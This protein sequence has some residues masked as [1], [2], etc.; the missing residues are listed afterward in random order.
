MT[1]RKLKAYFEA[2]PIK[3]LTDQPVKR[4]MSNPSI[5]GRLTMWAVELSEFDIQ[6]IPRGGVQ[7]HAPETIPAH[8]RGQG[9]HVDHLSRLATTYFEDIL[10]GVHVEVKDNPKHME[11]HVRPV[12]EE[13][14]D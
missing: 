11:H 9:K 14:E 10:K 3:V 1:V 12:L 6:Y 7:A 13:V 5:S 8:P 2:H 4:V